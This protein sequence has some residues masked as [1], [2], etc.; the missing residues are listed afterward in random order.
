MKVFVKRKM[1]FVT[2]LQVLYNRTFKSVLS[3]I[4]LTY[5]FKGVKSI[6]N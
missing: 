2:R 1:F 5:I 3:E 4:I 6:M